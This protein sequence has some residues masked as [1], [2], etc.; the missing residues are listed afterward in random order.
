MSL[1][2]RP[3]RQRLTPGHPMLEE[4]KPPIYLRRGVLPVASVV[5]FLALW[6]AVGASVSP[7][8]LATPLR[9]VQALINMISTGQLESA[10]A[11]AMADFS[12][13][14]S[15]AVVVG[16]VVGTW[17]GRSVI[18]EKAL[19]PYINFFQAMPSIAAIPLLVIWFGVGYPA[20]VATTF[21]LAVLPVII[22]T[23]TGVRQTPMMLREVAKIY[24]LREATVIRRIALPHALPHVFTGLRR[25]LGLGLIG[26]LI[27]EMEISV[28]GLGGLVITYG[29]DLQT[30]YL[31][32]GI[33]VAALVGV[34]AVAVL[35]LVRR[36]FFPWI[37]ALAGKG[38]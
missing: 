23:F 32:A 36:F 3:R 28:K 34:I 31:L 22:N 8:I 30:A 27:A 5:V 2:F 15:L 12:A 29:N 9:V 26:M 10:F 33:C 17:M 19:S 20:R 35:E 37:D 25:G 7:L 14:Y 11:T 13:G 21:W 4:S 24:K 16:I 1:T 18:A 38:S 6:Q